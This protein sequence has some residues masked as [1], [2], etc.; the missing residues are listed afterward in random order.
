MG[1]FDDF[2]FD[3]VINHRCRK[4]AAACFVKSGVRPGDKTRKLIQRL[5]P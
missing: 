1:D 2:L 4:D 5:N 3:P